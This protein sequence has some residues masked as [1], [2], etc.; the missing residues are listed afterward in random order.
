MNNKQKDILLYGIAM[1]IALA[2]SFYIIPFWGETVL[3]W[4]GLAAAM[5]FFFALLGA[6]FGHKIDR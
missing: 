5:F 3:F 2:A 4:L 6:V 1:I